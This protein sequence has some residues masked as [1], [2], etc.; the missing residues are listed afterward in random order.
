MDLEVSG[1]RI[2]LHLLGA[3]RVSAYRGGHVNSSCG[4]GLRH[5]VSLCRSTHDN[6]L[7]LQELSYSLSISQGKQGSMII[8]IDL[9]KAFDKIRWDFLDQTPHLF[10]F[11]SNIIRLIRS[12]VESSH[13]RILWNGETLDPIAPRCGLRQG[14]PLSPYLF[15]LFMEML[16]YMIKESVM[17]KVWDPIAFSRTGPYIS[18]TFFADDIILAIQ[19]NVKSARTIKDTLDVFC[20]ASG[21]KVSL[22]KSKVFF[23]SKTMI[24][25]RYEMASILNFSPTSHLE[26]YQG[27]KIMHSLNNS[28]NF[29]DL[30]ENVQARLSGWKVKNLNL[31]IRSTLIQLVT[32]ALPTYSMHTNW[33]PSKVCDHLDK[34]NRSFLWGSRDNVKKVHLVGWDK[35]IRWALGPFFDME[36]QTLA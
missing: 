13:L 20:L 16:S 10:K 29:R 35:V 15:V 23:A 6:I 32:L 25:V 9:E 36:N 4:C 17:N 24:I 5:E 19:S 27:V 30:I 28:N 31:S 12:C 7:V 21:L 1:N 14:D 26:K 11:P 22:S 2:G 18:H 8:T 33:L 3:L 34:I